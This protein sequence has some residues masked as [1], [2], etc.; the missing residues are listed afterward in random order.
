M[1]IKFHA[2]A[3]YAITLETAE[4][5]AFLPGRRAPERRTE[6]LGS[7]DPGV[8]EIRIPVRQ[9]SS[10]GAGFDAPRRLQG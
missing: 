5:E 3:M 6:K 9:D 7:S 10:G 8:W 1:I 2:T 4:K